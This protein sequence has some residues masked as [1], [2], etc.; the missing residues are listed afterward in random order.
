M[1]DFIKV[2]VQSILASVVLIV[3]GYVIYIGFIMLKYPE[4]DCQ[5]KNLI[6]QENTYDS[7]EYQLELIK[8]L[9]ESDIDDTR[10]W[11]GKYIDPTHITFQMQ[12]QN[13]CAEGLITVHKMEGKG[14]FMNQLMS[15]KG[16]SWGGALVGVKLKLTEDPLNPKI[17]LT[18]IDKIID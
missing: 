17:I 7:K 10:F 2:I 8:L 9:K 12:N 14:R 1:L 6:F 11:L 16:R 13:I 18:S 5:N 4:M 3:V 15:M